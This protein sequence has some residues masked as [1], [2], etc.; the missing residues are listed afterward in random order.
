MKNI[1]IQLLSI[2]VLA[3]STM[4]LAD[5]ILPHQPQAADGSYIVKWDCATNN[6]AT[7]NDME[8]DETFVFAVNLAGTPLGNWLKG[9][10]TSGR[11]RGVAFDKWR[12][13][14]EQN[15]MA[16]KTARL[17]LIRDTIYGATFN[18]KQLDGF[19]PGNGQKTQIAARLFGFET[20]IGAKCRAG[21]GSSIWYYWP[22]GW[23]EGYTSRNDQYLFAFAAYTGTKRNTINQNDYDQRDF[24]YENNSYIISAGYAPPCNLKPWPT[25]FGIS[26][27]KTEICVAAGERA[28]IT[29]QGSEV[30]WNYLLIDTKSGQNNTV[31]TKAGTGNAISWSVGAGGVYHV[32]AKAGNTNTQHSD[33][34][35]DCLNETIV[36][37]EAT[38]CTPCPDATTI[39][40]PALSLCEDALPYIWRGKTITAAGTYRDTIHTTGGRTCDSVYYEVNVT[41]RDCNIPCEEF[42]FRKWDDVLFVDNHED[43]FVSYQ[44]YKNGQAM[45]GETKQYLYTQESAM[46]GDGNT[47]YCMATDANG[48]SWPSCEQAFAL[49]SA[50]AQQP[51]APKRMYLTPNPCVGGTT[52]RVMGIG[53]DVKGSLYNAQGQL[54]MQFETTSLEVSLP[55]GCYVLHVTDETGDTYT[56]KITIL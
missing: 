1:R 35:G 25:I 16:D 49:F 14:K 5:N 4:A 37:T 46:K 21:A 51:Q 15:Q 33:L 43:R 20:P 27:D 19:T 23:N 39:T 12:G 22:S 48:Q 11:Q 44:W 32:E 30:G 7:S 13:G 36:I 53:D 41:L 9:N 34:M 56:E 40:D 3:A 24:F 26:T 38:D 17:W 31:G 54:L 50:S 8:Y 2:L 6:F 47:Y 42:V 52:I 45:T 55:T 18:F 10:A 29:V 28:T